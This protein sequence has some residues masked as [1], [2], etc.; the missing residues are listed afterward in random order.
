MRE[1]PINSV[2]PNSNPSSH[3]VLV[4]DDDKIVC[5]TLARVFETNGYEV[6]HAH[7]AEEAL[8]LL[9]DWAP[10]LAIVD[11]NLLKMNGVE[12]A[13]RIRARDPHCRMLLF[14]GRPESTELVQQAASEGYTFELVAKPI[15]PGHLLEWAREGRL[16][17]GAGSSLS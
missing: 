17:G 12:L 3:R 9:A 1:E 4:V 6:R 5:I 2:V 11:V 13:R 14:S 15:H 8:E 10:H 7:C 16:P